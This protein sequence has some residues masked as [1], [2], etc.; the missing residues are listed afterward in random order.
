MTLKHIGI[1]C[2]SLI[3]LISY[4]QEVNF[5]IEGKINPKLNGKFVKLIYTGSQ[6]RKI[7]SVAVKQGAFNFLGKVNS[8]MVAK[9]SFGTEDVGDKID[10]FLAEGMVR[11]LAK[12]SLHDASISGTKL[13]IEHELLARKLRPADDKFFNGLLTFKDMAEGEAKKTYFTNLMKGFD[14]YQLFRRETIHQFVSEHPASYVSLYYL[15]KSASGSLTNYETTYPFFAKLSAEIRATPVGKQ[16]EGRLLAAKGKMM[17]EIYKDFVSTT[18]AGNPLSL[19]EVIGKNKYTLIDFWA[20]WC[21][22]CRKENPNVVRAFTA[23]KE[24][25]FTVLSVSLD[26]DG[27]KWKAAIESDGMPWYHVSSLMGWKEPAAVLYGIRAIPQNVLVDSN[28]KIIATNLRA[29]TLYNKI[30]ELVSINR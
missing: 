26:D 5:T 19:K 9:L 12:D 4:S 8:P 7:D 3:P 1:L 15:D 11:V 14:G 16:L 21:G 23:F 20:S 17:G 28:G 24:K 2:L 29:E 13:A 27:A 25:G 22:P 6:T 10:I 18:P 30:Q